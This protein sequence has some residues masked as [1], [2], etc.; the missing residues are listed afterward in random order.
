MIYYTCNICTL[1]F[2][3]VDGNSLYAI[4]GTPIFVGS[5]IHVTIDCG[6]L[7]E[8][9]TNMYGLISTVTWYKSGLNLT[10]GSATNVVLSQDNRL[11]IIN[12]T[13]LISGGHIGTAGD[14]TCK[15]CRNSSDCKNKTSIHK[16]CG[17]WDL[18][19][20]LVV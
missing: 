18:F 11:C 6:P 19:L 9:V 14:Y 3:V 5:N 2:Y 1:C 17:E 10:N 13:V 15:V 16:V 4:V 7:I 8:N 20:N 12:N